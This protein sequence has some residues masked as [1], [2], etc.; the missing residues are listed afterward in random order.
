[1]PASFCPY[2][3]DSIAIVSLETEGWFQRV[4]DV[5]EEADSDKARESVIGGEGIL[6]ARNFAARYNLGVGD[7]V[8]L[9][10]PTEIFDRPIVGIIEDYTSEKGSIFMDR[11][12]YKRY[13]NDS[14]VDIIE[15]NLEAGTNA[16][17]IKTEIQRVTKGEH[18]AFIYTNSEYKS[19]VLN[20]INGFFVLNYMQMAIAI[21]VAALD[22][23]LAA[24]LGFRKKA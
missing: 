5:V 16:N 2:A 24:Y 13:W 18:R 15:V 23:Q 22:N 3:D 4:K 20:L 6:A 11:A 14:S 12:L 10:T 17:A 7:H 1:M 8:R 21:I 19:W 9:N